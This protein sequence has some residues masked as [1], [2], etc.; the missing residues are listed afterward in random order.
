[1]RIFQSFHNFNHGQVVQALGSGAIFPNAVITATN[2]F[3]PEHRG[4]IVGFWGMCISLGSAC[5]PSI[6]GFIT[7]FLGWPY[8]FFINL[9][10]ILFA[11]TSISLVIKPEVQEKNTLR[12]DYRG[13]MLLAS[14]IV[15]FVLVLQNFSTYGLSWDVLILMFVFFFCAPLFLKTEGKAEQAVLDLRLFKNTIFTSATTC[16]GV[17]FVANEGVNFLMPLFLAKELG[18][19][20]WP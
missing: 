6:G 12:F 9:P 11:L 19:D 10:I 16:G 14:L 8:L 1:M 20:S 4:K 15:S 5:G 7:Q 18:M 17:H 3:P 2:M 13:S